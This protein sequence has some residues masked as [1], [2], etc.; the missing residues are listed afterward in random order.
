MSSAKRIDG[1]GI[2]ERATAADPPRPRPRWAVLALA[3]LGTAVCARA[4]ASP[5]VFVHGDGHWGDLV[6]TDP[7]YSMNEYARV[8]TPVDPGA[9]EI[10]V[11]DSD[12]FEPGDLVLVWQSIGLLPGRSPGDAGPINLAG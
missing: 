4:H 5:D 2:F 12:A 11:D 9:T 3:L 1:R 10:E 6:V 7:G 8:V